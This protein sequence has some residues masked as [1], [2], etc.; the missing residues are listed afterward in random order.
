MQVL[1][2]KRLLQEQVTLFAVSPAPSSFLPFFFFKAASFKE[3]SSFCEL[4]LLIFP[5]EMCFWWQMLL[6]AKLKAVV[7]LFYFY[8]EVLQAVYVQVYDVIQVELYRLWDAWVILWHVDIQSQYLLDPFPPDQ[9]T[10]PLC[11]RLV[12][13]A[14]IYFWIDFCVLNLQSIFILFMLMLVYYKS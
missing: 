10:Q 2:T 4:N 6:I 7:I 9:L 12:G 13:Y 8:L 1:G 11:Q 5:L 3:Q 14:Q